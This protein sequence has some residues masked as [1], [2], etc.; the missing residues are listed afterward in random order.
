M[1]H[2]AALP[3]LPLDAKRILATSGAIAVHVGVLMMLM[4]P[5]ATQAPVAHEDIIVPNW[6]KPKE[7]PP[8]PPPPPRERPRVVEHQQA[9]PRPIPIAEPPPIVYDDEAAAVDGKPEFVPEVPPN[10]FAETPSASPFQQLAVAVGTAPPYPR[11][12]IT[13]SIEG[14]VMLRVHVDASGRPMEVSIE[15]SSGSRLLDEAALRHVKARWKFVPAQSNGQAVEAW[16]LVP[17]EFVLQ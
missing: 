6:E 2:A 10:T 5:P 14:T 8:P 11:N 15:Q 16:G 1:S 7:A 12:A 3:R 4:M 17:I 9:Q 13:R